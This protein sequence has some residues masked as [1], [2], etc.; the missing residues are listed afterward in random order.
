VDL[1]LPFVGL[2]VAGIVGVL[3][4]RRRL[5]A[6]HGAG[7]ALVE[8]NAWLRSARAAAAEG[9]RVAALFDEVPDER[10]VD[11]LPDDQLG[12]RIAELD[13]F[14]SQM[15]QVT[16]TAPTSMDVRV[17]RSV[18]VAATSL[19][20]SLRTERDVRRGDDCATARFATRRSGFR[21][22][23]RDLTTHVDLL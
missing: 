13:L 5:S 11:E 6:D 1:M 19:G 20:D 7:P 16:C 17:C 22:S 3:I 4:G 21:E 2:L 18:A 15:T 12:D 8:R 14:G 10:A 9:R 23:V